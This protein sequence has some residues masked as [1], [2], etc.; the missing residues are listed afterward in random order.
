MSKFRGESFKPGVSLARYIAWHPLAMRFPTMTSLHSFT[1]AVVSATIFGLASSAY[2]DVAVPKQAFTSTQLYQP[3]RTFSAAEVGLRPTFAAMHRGY[4]VVSGGMF[5]SS[6]D[7]AGNGRLTTWRLSQAAAPNTVNPS[8]VGVHE[9]DL[10]FKSHVLG[11]SGDLCQIRAGKF[12][13]YDL[14]NIA[15]PVIKGSAPGGKSSSHSSCWAGKY[16]YTGGEGYGT[17]SGWIDIYDVSNPAAPVLKRSVDIPT[18]TGFRCASVYVI[19]N[20]LVVSASLTNGIATFDLSDPTNP[21]LISVFR[22]DTAAS[23]YTSYLSG[24]RLYGGGQGGGLY[25]YDILDPEHIQL[26]E[27]V[28][29][30]GGTPR[31]PVV[32]DEYVHLG[33]LGNGHYQKLRVDTVPAQVVADV[34]MPLTSTGTIASTEIAIPIGNLV[35]V[36]NSHGN[37]ADPSGWLIPHDTAVDN[38]PPDVNGVRPLDGETNVATTSMIGVSFTDL[39][40]TPSIT[41]ASVIVRPVGTT[42]ALTGTY[43]NMGGIVNFS[44]SSPLTTNTTYEVVVKAGGV[45]DCSGNAFAA[46]KVYRFSTGPVVDTTAIGLTLHYPLD[47]TT[48]TVADDAVGTQN[49]TLNAFPATPWSAGLIGRGALTF[50]GVDDYVATPS[51]DVGNTFSF[52]TWVRVTSGSNNLE[53]IVGNT[54][55]GFQTA[56]FKCFVYGSTHTT[57]AG[58]IQVE[59]GDGTTGNAAATPLG[60]LP[61]DQWVHLAVTVDRAA[62]ACRIFV[63]GIDR[64]LDSTVMNNFTTAGPLTLGRMG[65]SPYFLGGGLDDFRLYSRVL[66]AGDVEQLRNRCE[67]PIDQWRV[68]SSVADSAPNGRPLTLSA[69][70]TSYDTTQ[71]NEGT[72]SLSLNGSTGYATTPSLELGNTFTLSAWVRV[73]SG[74]SGLKT[75]L[76]NG[77][78]GYIGNGFNLYVTG[79]TDTTPGKVQFETGNG[80][81]GNDARTANNVFPFDTWTHVAVGV[82]RARGIARIYINGVDRTTEGTIRN[83]FKTAGTI[84]IGRMTGGNN[85]F[86][87]NVDDVR[88]YPRWLADNELGVLAIGKL[89]GH[90]RFDGSGS[91]ESGFDRT[92]ALHGGAGFSN[93]A[94]HGEQS[95]NLDGIANGS[96]DYADVPAF[97]FGNQFS[98]SLWA[99]VTTNALGSRTVIA[100]ASGGAAGNGLRFF[101]NTWGTGDG[102]MIL[103]TGNGTL[104]DSCS[105]GVGVFEF[106][107]WNHLALVVDRAAGTAR[108]YYNRRD[109]TSDATIR[110]DFANNLLL[111]IGRLISGGNYHGQMDDLR[112]YAKKLT[113]TDIALLGAGSPDTAPVVSAFTSSSSA[114][115]TGT[116]LTFTATTSDPNLG[117]TLQYRYDFGDGTTTAWTTLN[118]GTHTYNVPG[119]YTVTVFVSDGT[120][121][122]SRTTTQ[123]AYNA[124]TTLPPSIS[125]EMAYDTT[126]NKVWCVV[127]DGDG[128]APAGGRAVRFDPIT[129]AVDYRVSLGAGAEPVALAMRPGNAEVW[130]ACKRS[131]EI[132]V[133][134]ANAGTVLATLSVGRGYLPVGVAFAPNGTAAFVTCEGAEGLQKWDPATRTKLLEVDLGAVPRGLAVSSDSARVFVSRFRSPD[135]QGEVWERN[136]ADLTAVR[137]IN[138]ARDTSTVDAPNAARGVPNYLSQVVLSPDGLK[139]WLPG[140]KDNISRG[141]SRDGNLLNHENTVRS[142]IAQLNLTTNVEN[143]PSRIDLDNTGLPVAACFSPRGDLL[144]VAAIGNEQVAVIDANSR[145]TLP[146]ISTATVGELFGFAPSGLCVSPDSA[147]LFVH[148]FLERKVRVFNISALTAGTGSTATLEGTVSL[149]VTEPFASNVLLGKKFFYNSE[150][151]RLAFEGYISCASCHLGGDQDGRVWDLTQF[152]EGLRN[153]IDLRGHAG[154]GLGPLHWSANFNEVQDFEDQIRKLSGGTGLIPPPGSPY[155]SLDVNNNATRSA[156]L[157]ALAT[158]VASLNTFPKSPYRNANGTMT[159]AAINGQAHFTSKGCVTCHSGTNFTDSSLSTFVL[160]DV[161]TINTQSGK[162]LDGPLTGLDTPSLRSL[163]VAPPYL[164]RGQAV[165][166][167]TIFN[168]TNAP[169][170]KGHDRYRELTT[171]QQDELLRYLL[172]LE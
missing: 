143:F 23:T 20:V 11:F 45:K 25:I 140:K 49:G 55:A 151:P 32:Q 117:D 71:A 104:G 83:D 51:L 86:G 56:G 53:T 129:R 68:N 147:R 139:A 138:L 171:T 19:G 34:A 17:A 42:T 124:P 127:P 112:L 30:L 88:V 119:R 94:V 77:P 41:N 70:G 44:P 170:G 33:N 89:L 120:F 135:A 50:D 108:I 172:E 161:G 102:R 159:T 169:A 14:A 39:L 35:F 1:R 78:S 146:A 82:D 28:T 37:T 63:N 149:T 118:T 18:I 54:A 166:L 111:Y 9:N 21:L 59:T 90:W 105:T 137:T 61:F 123:V 100:N 13:I 60:A 58:R 72:A 154:M 52:S 76:A 64:T 152:G 65:T 115:T 80:T 131:D 162:R 31:Y 97:D 66:V 122:V 24:H 107:Q 155:P 48:G 125:A 144:F 40:D 26:V 84:D 126:R 136:P 158:F 168:A 109:V 141:K 128:A 98:L 79:S 3:V 167:P 113:N 121:T 150:D 157:D 29:A 8:R 114:A 43:S 36:G 156:E 153:T 106:N 101:I 93:E 75:I 10:I 87:G 91:D 2:A 73:A 116:G 92:A 110:T 6:G 69:A 67:S 130:V 132:K 15:A 5:A 22:G 160:H 81:A 16:V 99:K 12:A 142:L 27:R 38:R 47:E 103:E 165:D 164:H 46:D 62:G 134:D 7:P 145:A 133:I 74:T 95:M 57:Y 163:W 85:Y 96:D 4:L 148:N